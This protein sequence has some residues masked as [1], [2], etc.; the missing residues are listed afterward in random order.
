ME[1]MPNKEG[2]KGMNGENAEKLSPKRLKSS[3]KWKA[4]VWGHCLER[5]M[6]EFPPNGS[7]ERL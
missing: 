5:E 6:C 7:L 4:E 2:R 1:L 3:G